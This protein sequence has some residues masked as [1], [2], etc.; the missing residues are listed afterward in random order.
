LKN[1]VII[2]IGSKTRSVSSVSAPSTS[3]DVGYNASH[4]SARVSEQTKRTWGAY[5]TGSFSV[6]DASILGHLG[7]TEPPLSVLWNATPFSFVADYILPVGDFYQS[8]RVVHPSIVDIWSSTKR[9]GYIDVFW[10]TSDGV[11]MP[12]QSGQWTLYERSAAAW[13]TFDG[14]QANIQPRS[15]TFFSPT[16]FQNLLALGGSFLNGR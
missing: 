15:V 8:P 9:V 1:K 14:I 5:V 13:D 6:L 12:L 4:L 3:D 2:W 7:L 16:Q 11:A 10:T